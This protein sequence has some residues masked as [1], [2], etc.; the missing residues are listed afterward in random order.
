MD[1]SW[2]SR[3]QPRSLG[4]TACTRFNQRKG[5]VIRH[6]LPGLSQAGGQPAEDPVRLVSTPCPFGKHEA[7]AEIVNFPNSILYMPLTSWHWLNPI[8][9]LKLIPDLSD[10][11]GTISGNR[12]LP[13]FLPI[14][15]V[16]GMKY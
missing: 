5:L 14:Q 2:A 9:A 10:P 12:F 1:A 11:N 4:S 3:A 16:F 8:K 15:Q 13:R 7:A 6:R